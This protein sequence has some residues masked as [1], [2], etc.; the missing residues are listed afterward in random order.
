MSSREFDIFQ[1]FGFLRKPEK[2]KSERKRKR[3]R[4]IFSSYRALLICAR[5]EPLKGEARELWERKVRYAERERKK[6]R[7]GH[8]EIERQRRKGRALYDQSYT[9]SR[10]LSVPSRSS[11]T[12]A[13][14]AGARVLI[15]LR[16]DTKPKSP[17]VERFM[18]F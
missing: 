13:A 11:R 1:N 4:M 2:R 17:A 5:L 14:V 9:M 16:Y 8:T 7:R 12:A 15:K 18:I 3:S 6:G 10:R